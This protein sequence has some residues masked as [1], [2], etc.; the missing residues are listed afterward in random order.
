[1]RFLSSMHLPSPH[2]ISLTVHVNISHH[3]DG[4]TNQWYL[5][6][7]S[8]EV[9]VVVIKTF[10]YRGNNVRWLQKNSD[11]KRIILIISDLKSTKN[12][13][14]EFLQ[15]NFRKMFLGTLK[16]CFENFKV[17][18]IVLDRHFFEK[19]MQTIETLGTLSFHFLLWKRIIC[20]DRKLFW[21]F[22]NGRVQYKRHHLRFPHRNLTEI[23]WVQKITRF[24]LS[25][26]RAKSVKF[27]IWSKFFV[28]RVP[29]QLF[30][31]RKATNYSDFA[32]LGNFNFVPEKWQVLC[33]LFGKHIK[34]FN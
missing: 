4:C 28:L 25:W 22:Q 26:K 3:F 15:Q 7:Q 17:S 13:A 21:K 9:V 18:I 12:Q 10:S 8:A 32:L 11:I 16:N 29:S 19:A 14:L 20:L 34:K 30:T 33:F 24:L 5:S 27:A 2:K 6:N 1:M 31:K 23:L